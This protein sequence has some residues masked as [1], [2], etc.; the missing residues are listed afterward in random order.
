MEQARVGPLPR[1]GSETILLVD[2]EEHI[3]DL[4]SR[5][6]AKAGYKVIAAT[7]GKEA[8]EMYEHRGDEIALV[9][10]DLSMPEMGGKQCLEGLLRLNSSARV[11]VASG[12]SANG[13]TENVIASEVKGFVNKPYDIR[14]L[15]EVVRRVLGAD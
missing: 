13:P 4:G 15:L 8:L 12:Y 14:K 7:N 10:L 3:R 5:I 11:V 6:L 9:V 2:D 1:G